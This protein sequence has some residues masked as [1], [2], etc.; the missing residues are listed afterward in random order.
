ME[1]DVEVLAGHDRDAGLS[2]RRDGGPEGGGQELSQV[3]D[4]VLL[5]PAGQ[6]RPA[7]GIQHEAEVGGSW[8]RLGRD[9]G[10][11]FGFG[12]V[13]RWGETLV[14]NGES[15]GWGHCVTLLVGQRKDKLKK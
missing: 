10:L 5:P 2:D 6:R 8:P 3:P 15:K 7:G 4:V 12:V 14:A 13:S 11:G 1:G 9:R